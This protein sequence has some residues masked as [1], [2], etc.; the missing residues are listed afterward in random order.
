M[1]DELP[2]PVAMP[3]G[4]TTE[5]E[6]L[7]W[8]G[9]L[10]AELPVAGLLGA[11][12]VTCDPRRGRMMV[13]FQARREFCNLMGTI[14]GGML[15]AMLDLAMAFAVLCSLDD[16]H[17]VPSLEIKT[18]FLAPARPG[19]IIGEGALLRKGRTIAFAEARLT[20]P[21]GKLLATASATGQIRLRRSPKAKDDLAE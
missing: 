11:R 21:H 18:T 2:P 14:Q 16:G 15:T 8:A 12:P 3:F 9:R 5:P 17:V 7:D 19:I 1:S 10:F 4:R 20:D 13:E 6:A